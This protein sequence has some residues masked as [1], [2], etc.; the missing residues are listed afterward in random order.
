MV[1]SQ[2]IVWCFVP[3]WFKNN[4]VMLV[5]VIYISPFSSRLIDGK[6]QHPVYFF[7]FH[8]ISDPMQSLWPRYQAVQANHYI[9]SSNWKAWLFQI[10]EKQIQFLRMVCHIKTPGVQMFHDALNYHHL[11]SVLMFFVIYIVWYCSHYQVGKLHKQ[12][13]MGAD[14]LHITEYSIF[15]I[16]NF[17]QLA[18]FLG[19]ERIFDIK[20]NIVAI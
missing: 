7:L 17:F 12:T 19:T 2:E 16:Q 13:F 15:C 10:Y 6:I 3:S 5:N 14:I 9:S 8:M 4:N 20:V 11:R 1:C 18:H